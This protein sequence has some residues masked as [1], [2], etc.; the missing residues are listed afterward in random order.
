[1]QK[2]LV[3]QTEKG[4]TQ[5]TE[6]YTPLPVPETIWEDLSMDFLLGLLRT[7]RGMDYIFVVVD[8]FSKMAHFISCRKTSDATHLAHLF[9]R[10][11]VQLHGVP[12]SITSDR[13]VKFLIHFWRTLWRR[14]DTSLNYSSTRHPQTN[15]QT[16][17]TNRTLRNMLR[18]VSRD[19]PK[20]W[21]INIPQVEF[22]FNCMSN[23]STG[24]S[25]FEVVYTKPLKHALD[26]VSLPKLLGL[27]VAAEHMADRVQQ[28]HE[29]VRLNLEK[30]NGKYKDA[31]DSKRGVKI[32]REG[33]LV[34]AHLRKNRFPAG[35]YGKLK[36]RKYGPFRIKRKI[37]D[38]AYVVELPEDMAIS[39]T[40]NV[41]DLFAYHPDEPIYADSNSRTSFLEEGVSDVEQP[42]DS[43]RSIHCIISDI[44]RD[45][46]SGAPRSIHCIISNI[47]RD[48]DFGAPRQ[49]DNVDSVKSRDPVR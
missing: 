7:Q 42:E 15:G 46:D 17:V 34:M 49:I 25:P 2:Y 21:D 36:S 16:E 37:N 48:R 3:C 47:V 24:K 19:K 4:S 45:G 14:F 20:Q 9:F 11:V 32:F 23:R 35:T 10:E 29:E 39:N 43:T 18:C 12:K 26:L 33:D 1:V 13:D 6:L 44:V 28:I 8:R 41:A 27:N 40:F 5:N 22:A 38:N 30:A 31:A